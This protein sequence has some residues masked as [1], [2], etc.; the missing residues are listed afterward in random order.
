METDRT[1]LRI[2][3]ELKKDVNAEAIKT[4]YS[5]TLIYKLLI[6]LIWLQLV[7]VVQN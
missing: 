6:T 7:T 4:I 5:K 1:G 2:A 3:I